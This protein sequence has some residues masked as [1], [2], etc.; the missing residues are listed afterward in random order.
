MARK[1]KKNFKPTELYQTHA[2]LGENLDCAVRAI[3]VVTHIS[4][5]RAHAALAAKGRTSERRTEREFMWAVLTDLGYAWKWVDPRSVIKKYPGK[6][7]HKICITSHQMDRFPEAWK[8][9]K[10]Y[11][12]F[13]RGHV[14]AIVDGVNHDW[15]RGRSLRCKELYEVTRIA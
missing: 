2:A 5:K 11:L 4:Y 15:S 8:D 14:L 7:R 6:H 9:G 10:S 3:A 1:T 12:F 13:S